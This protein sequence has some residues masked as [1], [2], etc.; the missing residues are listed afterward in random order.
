[1]FSGK[2]DWDISEIEECSPAS[3]FSTVMCAAILAAG[4]VFQKSACPP[5]SRM[6][7]GVGNAAIISLRALFRRMRNHVD[8][9][10]QNGL[11]VIA[12]L[13]KSG[14]RTPASKYP[15]NAIAD[16]EQRSTEMTTHHEPGVFPDVYCLLSRPFRVTRHIFHHP[17]RLCPVCLSNL[18]R[19]C[20]KTP[21]APH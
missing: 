18:R 17:S 20:S 2:F 16:F 6:L 5:T 14:I 3:E 11:S 10:A 15:A 13:S 21:G 4:M 8:I 1:M 7:G 9:R 19:Y 12:I